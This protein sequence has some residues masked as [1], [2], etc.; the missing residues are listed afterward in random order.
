MGLIEALVPYSTVIARAS[1]TQVG[2]AEGKMSVPLF[3]GPLPLVGL[4]LLCC[5]AL[6]GV[7]QM[8][9]PMASQCW[10]GC[11]TLRGARMLA[12]MVSIDPS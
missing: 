2:K 12:Q 5:Y 11:L 1:Q 9:E 6:S 3:W 7:W 8:A 4:A 10:V